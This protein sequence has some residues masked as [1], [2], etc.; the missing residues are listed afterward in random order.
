[1]SAQTYRLLVTAAAAA[2]S[3]GLF[4]QPNRPSTSTEEQLRQQIA[5]LQTETGLARPA[6]VIDPLRA[7]ALLY[8]EE[9]DFAL[10]SATLEEAR[11][12]TR[13]H[14]GLTSADEAL[15]LRQQ[16]RSEKAL[17]LHERAW[18]LEQDMVTIARHH[19]EDI[20]MLPIFRE[21]AENRLDVIEKVARSERPPMIYAGCYNG[22]PLPPYDYTRGG[23]WRDVPQG[24]ASGFTTPSCYGGINQDLIVKLH[25][26]TLMYYADA[27]EIILRTGDYASQELRELERA[28]VRVRNGRSRSLNSVQSGKGG[29][30]FAICPSGT[31]DDYLALEILESCLAPVARGPGFVVAN[32][33]NPLGLIRLMQY[34][35]RSAAPPAARANAIADLADWY[36]LFTPAER[37]RFNLPQVAFALY[38]RAYRELEQSGD[39]K[40]STEMFAPELPVTLPTYEPNPFEPAATEPGRYIDVSFA[41]TKYGLGERIEIL[42]TSENATREE[43]QDLIRLIETTTFRPRMT[44]GKIADEAPVALRYYLQ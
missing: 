26:E 13:V 30:S 7:L 36:V 31:L 19:H 40:A 9:G 3:A 34:E 17:G 16:V 14:N 25:R 42:G 2:V 5:E 11:Y 15:L 41:I 20:R 28:A 24:Q 35:I 23:E 29:G 21:L 10:A 1:M 43:K 44:N 39:L 27:I 4:A 22:E 33:G 8:E 12:V 6:E 37:R 18:D 32:V 38:Q